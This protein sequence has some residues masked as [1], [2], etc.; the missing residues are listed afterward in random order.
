[1]RASG[2]SLRII[3]IKEVQKSKLWKICNLFIKAIV[4]NGGSGGG[5]GGVVTGLY[6]YKIKLQMFCK[7]KQSGSF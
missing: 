6:Q 2:V 3:V 7:S 5:G 4:E 1:M